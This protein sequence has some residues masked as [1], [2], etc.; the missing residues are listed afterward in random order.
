MSYLTGKRSAQNTITAPSRLDNMWIKFNFNYRWVGSQVLTFGWIWAR[1]PP[2]CLKNGARCCVLWG[3]M[4]AGWWPAWAHHGL[5]PAGFAPHTWWG[6]AHP[7]QTQLCPCEQRS[8]MGKHG[9]PSCEGEPTKGKAD[10]LGNWACKWNLGVCQLAFLRGPKVYKV[11]VLWVPVSMWTWS[12]GKSPWLYRWIADCFWWPMLCGSKHCSPSE[13]DVD[14]LKNMVLA[15]PWPW[16]IRSPAQ[17][18][19]IKQPWPQMQGHRPRTQAWDSPLWQGDSWAACTPGA[20]LLPAP[21]STHTYP[22]SF[23]P[24]KWSRWHRE[25]SLPSTNT[26]QESLSLPAASCTDSPKKSRVR[27]PLDS[28]QGGQLCPGDEATAG[29]SQETSMRLHNTQR[30]KAPLSQ[31]LSKLKQESSSTKGG[32]VSYFLL[33]DSSHHLPMHSWIVDAPFFPWKAVPTNQK[34]TITP[35]EDTTVFLL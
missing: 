3:E 35:Q 4:K 6:E 19:G 27:N 1:T 5:V 28:C 20:P 14:Y 33:E 21:R 30:E 11:F 17:Q 32:Y 23:V 9:H 24:Q 18:C 8:C 16:V 10:E 34:L 26:C 7:P 25:T 31:I 22:N 2:Q 29:L 13:A 15:K 12:L